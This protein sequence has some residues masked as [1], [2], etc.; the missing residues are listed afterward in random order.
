MGELNMRGTTPL[1]ARLLFL[2]AAAILALCTGR[3]AQAQGRVHVVAGGE[4]LSS[5][6]QHYGLSLQE[7]AAYNGI[8]NP[9]LVFSGQRLEIPGLTAAP[10]AMAP[11]TSETLPGD[12]GYY[13][14]VRGDTLSAI[15]KQ[16]GMSTGD[17]LRLNNISNASMIWVGQQLRVSAR[18]AA[19]EASGPEVNALAPSV[20]SGIYVVR[21]GDTLA[22][23]AAANDSTVQQLLVANG[24]PSANYIYPGQR[25][26]LKP[27][28]AATALN[29][30]AAPA[31]GKRWIEV[32]L[33][34]QTLTAWQGD[35]A[36]LRTYISSGK[37][38]TPTVTGRFTIDRKYKAQ[39]MTGPG[40]DLPNVPWVMYFYSAYAI[41]GA[42]WR[43]AFGVPGSHG[44]VNMSVSEAGMLYEWA[45]MGTEVYVHY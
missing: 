37:S 34:D 38:E 22:A 14:V 6:A 33:T 29:L 13:T 40:Y 16:F 20:A 5:I 42:Y 1:W 32:N 45:A 44:C 18:A 3:P 9:N 15:A 17:L 35:V 8:A 2:A 28:A 4:N 21:S 11:A 10:S 12:S 19:V 43:N 7:L 39:R 27:D 23:I 24:L 36:V 41:H 26:R 31:E 25:L 30:V